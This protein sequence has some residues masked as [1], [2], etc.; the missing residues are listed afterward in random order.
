M[1]QFIETTIDKFIFRVATDRLYSADGIWA[2][3][4]E[5]RLRVGLTDF[6]QQR[7]GDVAFVHVKPLGT[8]LADA[9]ELAELETIKINQSLFTPA[10]GKIVEINATLDLTPEVINQDPY[11]KG[12]LALIEPAD[13]DAARSKLLDPDAYL[14]AIRSQAEQELAG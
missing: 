9:D 10:P 6:L 14:A 12:W 3:A 11:G 8:A 13:W 4:E 1:Q 5:G 7:S 2:R